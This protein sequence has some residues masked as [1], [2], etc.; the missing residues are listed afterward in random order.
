MECKQHPELCA[1]HLS[2]SFSQQ[3]LKKLWSGRISRHRRGGTTASVPKGDPR[4]SGRRLK[5]RA[6]HRSDSIFASNCI[7]GRTSPTCSRGTLLRLSYPVVA[8]ARSHGSFSFSVFKIGKLKSLRDSRAGLGGVEVECRFACD[9]NVVVVP[10]PTHMTCL[11]RKVTGS[12]PA[13]G[14]SS[15]H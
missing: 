4:T 10:H 1:E 11:E 9:R 15:A 7:Q 12:S 13:A 5:S 8:P 6:A 2:I 3:V 14:F